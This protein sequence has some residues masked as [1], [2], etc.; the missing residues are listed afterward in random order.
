MATV[1]IEFDTDNAAFEDDAIGEVEAIL[2]RVGLQAA[3]VRGLSGQEGGV[4]ADL[5]GKPIRD[6]YGNTVGKITVKEG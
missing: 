6:T 1:R 4:L 5:D 2:K 3:S